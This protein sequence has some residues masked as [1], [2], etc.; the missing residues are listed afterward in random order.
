MAGIII[1]YHSGSGHTKIAAEHIACGALRETE[2]VHCLSILEAQENFALLHEAHAIV[3]GCPTYQGNISSDF[4]KFMEATTRFRT[5]LQWS[6]KLAAGFTCSTC[7]GSG[8]FFTLVTLA[9]FAAQHGMLWISD[10]KPAGSEGEPSIEQATGSIG[11]VG[12][13]SE[14]PRFGVPYNL[15]G[16]EHFGQ[17]IARLTRQFI[18][19]NTNNN[20]TD[21]FFNR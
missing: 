7:D 1:V 18:T 11:F 10:K 8:S 2:E 19:N 21:R 13:Y 3:F 17:R 6:D 4:K 14:F 15:A 9:T 16:A 12:R 5:S 20:E